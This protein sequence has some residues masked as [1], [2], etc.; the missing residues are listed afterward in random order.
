ML[1]QRIQDFI[2]SFDLGKNSTEAIAQENDFNEFALALFRYQFENNL[3]YQ[4][5]C[6]NRGISP[7]KVRRLQDIPAV[8][9][10]SFK[11]APLFC[12]DPNKEAHRIFHTSGTTKNL[13]GKHY[14]KTLE[15]YRTTSLRLFKWACLPDFDKMPILVLAPTAKLFP[16][17]SL[18]Q[19]FS[20]I[21]ETYGSPDSA[22]CF[23]PNGLQAR[24][25]TNWL[26][27]HGEKDSPILILAA[28]LA[29]ID[30]VENEQN[31]QRTH[32]LPVGSRII[33]TGGY[34]SSR[35]RIDQAEFLRLVSGHF[36]IAEEWIFNEYG[37]TEMSSQFYETRFLAAE[38]GRARKVA[39]PWVKSFA[40]DPDTLAILPEGEKGVL[41][42]FDLTNLDSVA[43]LQTEDVGIV[44]GRTIELFGRD[45][46]AE[47]R[48]CSLLAEELLQI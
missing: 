15:L 12:G 18:G 3:P 10:T 46:N 22:V 26:S 41:R 5:L 24:K 25:A 11:Y 36:G 16:N 28:S 38:F 17:S 23:S 33:D 48:G 40:C 31:A 43:M 9:T 27:R 7:E 30:F 39:P 13:S 29:L 6:S 37:M 32:P 44:R 47:P 20:W 34:K 19:M 8:M 45:P 35:R 2:S 42:H 21:M 14:F 1:Q 4:K